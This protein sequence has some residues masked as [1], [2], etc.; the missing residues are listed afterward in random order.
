MSL[1]ITMTPVAIYLATGVWF[2]IP[3]D[4]RRSIQADFD[5]Y[6]ED[7]LEPPPGTVDRWRRHAFEMALLRLWVWPLV[8]LHRSVSGPFL[9]RLREAVLSR[10]VSDGEYDWRQRREIEELDRELAR[11]RNLTPPPPNL[12]PPNLETMQTEQDR[13]NEMRLCDCSKRGWHR[14]PKRGDLWFYNKHDF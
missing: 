11:Q 6:A 12:E 13:V 9:R 2:F 1:L 5:R 14:H 4:V 10:S 7:G 8:L 3:A